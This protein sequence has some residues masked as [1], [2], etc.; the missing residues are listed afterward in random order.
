MSQ[1]FNSLKLYYS[2]NKVLLLA[3]IVSLVMH[4]AL[5]T[6]FSLTLP[7]QLDN[8]QTL[9]MRLVKL[10]PVQK[11]SPAPIKEKIPKPEAPP[12]AP[13][14][15]IAAAPQMEPTMA[16]S[17]DID[18]SVDTSIAQAED[19]S[20]QEVSPD[21]TDTDSMPTT[22]PSD[23][24]EQPQPQAYKYVDTLFE[25]RRGSDATAAGEA[26]IIFSM[27]ADNTYRLTSLTEAK[28]LASLIFGKLRQV[29]EGV[30]TDAGLVPHYYLYQYGNDEKKMQHAD[31]LWSD[32]V[33]E[34]FSA[35]GRKTEKLSSGTQDFLSFM[36]QFM[37][38][39]P[40]EINTITMTN[41][42]KLRTYTYSFQGEELI[43][44]KFAILNAIHLLKQG[45]E[46]EKTELWLATDYQYLPIKIRKT[47][48]NGSV[49]EQTA[50]KISTMAP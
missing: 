47:E 15:P 19:S 23:A 41:G 45:D 33:L 36:Y 18:I 49:I 25:V 21:I 10:Q 3:V 37:F 26:R 24:A 38:T 22:E 27:T 8:Q 35:K 50:I 42:K 14:K 12:T 9:T 32:G 1:T 13:T 2:H 39:P 44:T 29:S 28:G 4:A 31:L 5:V 48:K 43:Q 46:E 34:M 30:V 17:D 6:K 16:P 11:F 40:L 20:T 7:A